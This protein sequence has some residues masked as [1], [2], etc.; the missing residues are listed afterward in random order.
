MSLLTFIIF[1]IH[2]IERTLYL[3]D[4]DLFGLIG[5]NFRDASVVPALYNSLK[6]FLIL[7]S[8]FLFL[9]AIIKTVFV[10][11]DKNRR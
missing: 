1:N 3:A 9:A 5:I 11:Q 4:I 10:L 8:L 2:F 6:L 7:T